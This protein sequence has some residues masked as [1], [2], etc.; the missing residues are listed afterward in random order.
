MAAGTGNTPPVGAS[1]A[2]PVMGPAYVIF[3]RR[4]VLTVLDLSARLSVFIFV[5]SFLLSL[6]ISAFLHEIS[7]SS[8]EILNFNKS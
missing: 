7:V 2:E 8:T 3:E 1:F 4:R 6:S 5:T